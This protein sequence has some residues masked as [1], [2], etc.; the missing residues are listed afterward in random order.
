LKRQAGRE[1]PAVSAILENLRAS[2]TGPVTA[3]DRLE[4][5]RTL[6]NVIESMNEEEREVVLLRFFQDR[7]ID[8]IAAVLGRSSTAVRRLVGRALLRMGTE[9]GGSRVLGE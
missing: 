9:L 1:A 3:A 8:E 5:R 7:T 6:E 4:R 2:G